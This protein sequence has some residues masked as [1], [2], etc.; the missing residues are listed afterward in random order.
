MTA[1]SSPGTSEMNSARPGRSPRSRA[2]PPPLIRESLDRRALSSD[3][4]DPAGETLR[5]ELARTARRSRRPRAPRRGWTLP[6][7]S[8]TAVPPSE[9]AH[10]TTAADP[11]PQPANACQELGGRSREISTLRSARICGATCPSF[12]MTSVRSI[13]T[14][15]T[16]WAPRAIAEAAFP[17]AAIQTGPEGAVSARGNRTAAADPIEA[18]LK[19]L[20]QKAPTDSNSRASNDFE[21]TPTLASQ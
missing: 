17:I 15:S 8:E 11:G 5:I 9:A 6:P 20:E 19:Q 2:M 18:G 16:S 1:G 21:F 14:P 10:S 7:R 12:V 4:R 3:D 13:D